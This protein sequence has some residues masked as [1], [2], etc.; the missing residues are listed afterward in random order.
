[1]KLITTILMLI[2]IIL[3][4]NA[5][6]FQITDISFNEKMPEYRVQH[7]KN[8][9]LGQLC[10]ITVFDKDIQLQPLDANGEAIDKPIIMQLQSDGRFKA[11]KT[12]NSY[13]PH[14]YVHTII[15]T[16]EKVLGYYRSLKIEFW[17]NQDY[18]FT[19]TLKRK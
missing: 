19:L 13:A 4:S 7:I 9:R 16:I 6:T 12:D 14:I 17:K 8:Q 1:M 18:L 2:G 3:A 10:N 15:M 5:Q 11:T